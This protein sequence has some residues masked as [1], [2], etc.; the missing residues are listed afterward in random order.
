[1][2]TLILILIAV[3]AAGAQTR[4]VTNSDLE[5]FRRERI[6]AEDEYR[7]NYARRGMPSPEE[8]ARIRELKQRELVEFSERLREQRLANEAEIIDRANLVRSQL[9]SVDSQINYLRGI[10]GSSM[11]QPVSYWS[12]AYQDFGYRRSVYASQRSP[13]L[14]ANLQTVTDISRM[15]PNST[16]VYNRS[17]GNYAFQNQRPRGRFYGGG[18][19][20]PVV[21]TVSNSNEIDSQ[22]VYLEQ[23]RAGL[24]AEWRIIEEEARRAEIRID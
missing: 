4:T 6:K 7:Q 24:I 19:L 22:L 12:Y 14:P 17:I 21:V 23:I 8:L 11:S 2:K 13:Q 3:I 18:F 9:A 1:M 10:R 20:V 15:Y 5:K 16:D